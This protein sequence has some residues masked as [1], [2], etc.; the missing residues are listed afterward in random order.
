MEGMARFS[1]TVPGASN[2]PGGM[3]IPARRDNAAHRL[4]R[5]LGV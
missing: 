2:G 1:G 3:L 5:P 4:P